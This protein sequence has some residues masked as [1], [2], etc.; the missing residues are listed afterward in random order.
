LQCTTHEDSTLQQEMR[1]EI[2]ASIEKVFAIKESLFFKSHTEIESIEKADLQASLEISAIAD[3][4]CISL[5]N[6]NTGYLRYFMIL[7]PCL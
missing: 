6:P 5:L 4:L 7:V 2:R 1:E 3:A